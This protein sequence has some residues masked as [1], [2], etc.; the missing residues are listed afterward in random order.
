MNKIKYMYHND[1]LK[2]YCCSFEV[3]AYQ[4]V[5]RSMLEKLSWA[6]LGA[7]T[8]PDR[9]LTALTDVKESQM[10]FWRCI[11]CKQNFIDAASVEIIKSLHRLGGLASIYK[12]LL[13]HP[14]YAE[15]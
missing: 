12:Y 1:I 10:P 11:N 14:G 4:L 5:V 7:N 2:L 6:Y 13:E 15:L 8:P 9:F 3:M